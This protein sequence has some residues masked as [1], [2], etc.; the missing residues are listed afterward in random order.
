METPP[1]VGRK[2]PRW[3][4]ESAAKSVE[5][6]DSYNNHKYELW[7]AQQKSK[8]VTSELNH[9]QLLFRLGLTYVGIELHPKYGSEH[10]IHTAIGR[11][12]PWMGHQMDKVL[13]WPASMT[14]LLP[15]SSVSRFWDIKKESIGLVLEN[16]CQKALIFPFKMRLRG[17]KWP[18]NFSLNQAHWSILK[19]D[20]PAPQDIRAQPPWGTLVFAETTRPPSS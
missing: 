2:L 11:I 20:Q 4:A 9:G 13:L 1:P 8:L 3:R 12:I 19:T 7:Q 16:I 6:V 18:D 5:I 17:F 10:K 15:F 14:Q